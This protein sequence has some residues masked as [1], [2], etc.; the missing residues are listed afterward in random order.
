MIPHGTAV[1][2]TSETIDVA[3]GA[4]VLNLLSPN[5]IATAIPL[6][7]HKAYIWI[8]SGPIS[9]TENVGDGIER[10]KAYP[11]ST[12]KRNSAR[13]KSVDLRSQSLPLIKTVGVPVTL[14]FV[15]ES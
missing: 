3:C 14:Y 10:S 5:Q 1:I 6:I 2:A 12:A 15:M 8:V 7:M 11:A 9:T 4:R 13:L